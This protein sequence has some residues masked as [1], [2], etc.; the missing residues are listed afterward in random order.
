MSKLLRSNIIKLNRR[1]GFILKRGNAMY[2][3][4]SHRNPIVL[5]IIFISIMSFTSCSKNQDTD[6][7]KNRDNILIDNIEQAANYYE[8]HPAFEEAFEFLK[9]ST[10]AELPVG[11]HEINGEKLFCLVAKDMGRSRAEAKL[12]AHRKYIDI[13][14]IISGTDEMGWKP[15]ANCDS[16][17]QSYN[18]D[19]DIEFFKDDPQTWTKVPAGSFAIFFPED[20]HAPMVDTEEIHKVVL[21]VLLEQ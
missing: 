13:Q 3:K 11:R 15:T 5:F 6:S 10:L 1:I 9:M 14:Y 17:D 4:I 12:E 21:K 19:N 16:I 8:M 7:P 20:A 2:H 18:I